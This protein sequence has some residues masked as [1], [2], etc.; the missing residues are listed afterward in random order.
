M[1]VKS[2]TNA[3]YVHFYD[4]LIFSAAVSYFCGFCWTYL[5][6][7]TCSTYSHLLLNFWTPCIFTTFDRS[8][9][10]AGCM[11]VCVWS[12]HGVCGCHLSN[13]GVL[14]YNTHTHTHTVSFAALCLLYL[15]SSISPNSTQ[16]F[17]LYLHTNHLTVFQYYLQCALVHFPYS[18]KS[19]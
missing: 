5:Y 9:T 17:S 16:R 13:T 14:H 4:L 18:L 12:H 19:V 10:V 7:H 2:G 11:C 1:Y 15:Y 3:P 6:H 8:I